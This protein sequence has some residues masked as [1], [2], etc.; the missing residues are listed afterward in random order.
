MTYP[1]PSDVTDVAAVRR[2]LH[3]HPVP[4]DILQ[5]LSK[6]LAKISGA[7]R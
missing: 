4:E 7:G 6:Y 1:W 3:A 5:S 2:E